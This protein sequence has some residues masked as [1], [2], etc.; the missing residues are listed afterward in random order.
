MWIFRLLPTFQALIQ[1]VYVKAK[2]RQDLTTSVRASANAAILARN[3][4]AFRQIAARDWS[5]V[6]AMHLIGWN[7]FL[8]RRPAQKIQTFFRHLLYLPDCFK[9]FQILCGFLDFFHLSR[10][11]YEHCMSKQRQDLTSSVRA[12]GNSVFLA[13][14]RYS[15]LSVDSGVW[16]VE[17]Q[18]YKCTSLAE[19]LFTN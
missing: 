7:C 8:A 12:S 5:S 18:C 14:S 4:P 6:G 17:R 13:R 19:I 1:T 3:V 16:S 11:W 2:Q 10:L 15:C 9:I